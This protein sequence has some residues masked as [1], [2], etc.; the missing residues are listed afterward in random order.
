EALRDEDFLVIADDRSNNVDSHGVLLAA[1]RYDRKST[2]QLLRLKKSMNRRYSFSFRRN[3]EAIVL[4]QFPSIVLKAKKPN[5]EIIP[6]KFN[7]IGH[8]ILHRRRELG[9]LQQDVAGI[10]NVD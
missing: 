9:L 7:T 5:I 4:S 1:L 10:L 6:L 3:I 2:K 8:H